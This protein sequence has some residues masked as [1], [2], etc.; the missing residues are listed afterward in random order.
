MATMA[1]QLLALAAVA[2]TLGGPTIVPHD[3]RRYMG[4]GGKN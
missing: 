2:A 4:T 3:R 1:K